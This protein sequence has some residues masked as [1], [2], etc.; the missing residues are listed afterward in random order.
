MAPSFLVDG[1]LGSL[2]R[3]LRICGYETEY[4]RDAPDEELLERGIEAH[5]VVLTRDIALSKEAR[6]RGIDVFIVEG[7]N[8]EER[9]ASVA[10]E[11]NL[12]LDPVMARCTICGGRLDP[13]SKD[14]VVGEVPSASLEAYDEFWR[15]GGCGKVYWKGSHWKRIVEKIAEASRLADVREPEYSL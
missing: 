5:F 15:C 12:I 11:F 8:D 9:L 7:S 2:N 13:V 3:W 6:R 1:M 10:Q 4:M 14:D